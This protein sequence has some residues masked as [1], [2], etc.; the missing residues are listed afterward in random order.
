MSLVLTGATSQIGH[1]L[2][3]RLAQ[4]GVPVT[5]ISRRPPA[6]AL[7]NERW[8]Q[9]DL[10]GGL[11]LAS[12]SGAETL[13]SFGPLDGL[14]HWL[15]AQSQ[16]PFKRIIATGS[17]SVES[18]AASDDASERALV[19][20]LQAGEAGVQ[21]TCRRLGIAWTIFRP[22]LIYG[23]GL[24]KSL[25]PIA[26]RAMRTRLF[27]IPMA[28]GLRQPVHADDIAQAVIAALDGRADN[29]IIRI[30]G[31]ERLA[32]QQMFK[33][34]RDSLPVATLPV[35][36]PHLALEVLTRLKPALRGPVSRLDA[37]LVADNTPLIEQLGVHPRAFAPVFD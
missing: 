32:Y 16:L 18:K 34:V 35:F 17:M 6:H 29:R 33:R 5:A 4:R 25:T 19:A 26:R 36:V 21:Q 27:P 1:Y 31:G 20:R 23:A 9:T 30:G 12:L 13:V 37:D 10:A 8:L 7:P 28:Q 11:P 2:R 24:D 22:T 14:G 3:P 15:D